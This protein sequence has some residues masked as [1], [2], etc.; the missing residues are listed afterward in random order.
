MYHLNSWPF[1]VAIMG[2]CGSQNL[3]SGKENA[4]GHCHVKGGHS[5]L[6]LG[7]LFPQS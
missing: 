1:S 6:C 2:T 3:K 4:E 5:H 7:I